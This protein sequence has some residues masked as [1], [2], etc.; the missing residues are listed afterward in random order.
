MAS[1]KVQVLCIEIALSEMSF[2]QCLNFY[3]QRCLPFATVF[4]Q[5]DIS[6]NRTSFNEYVPGTV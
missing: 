1:H 6:N 2:P 4:F 5:Y 3:H